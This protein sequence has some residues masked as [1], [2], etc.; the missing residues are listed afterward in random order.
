MHNFIKNNYYLDID[1]IMNKCRTGNTV[2][3]EDGKEVNEINVFKYELIKMMVERILDEFEDET[4]DD[5]LSSLKG[6]QGSLS[7]NLAFNTLYQY[8]IIK[9][10][11][12]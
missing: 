6:K 11:N 2:Q 10:E 12:D 4:D 5:V 1:G 3:D 7:F 8:G 9:E